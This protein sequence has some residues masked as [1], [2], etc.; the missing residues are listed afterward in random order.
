MMN[1]QTNFGLL[2]HIHRPLFMLRIGAFLF[3]LGSVMGMSAQADPQADAL[4]SKVSEVMR[5]YESIHAT[6]VSQMLDRQSDFD[7]E[8]T[9][10]VW[11]QGEQYHLQLGQYT[12]I[13]D[14]QTVWTH[15]P[16]M[17]ECYVDDAEVIAEDGIDPASMFTI[18]ESGF[19]KV[20]K[21]EENVGGLTLVRV[22]LHPEGEEESSFHTIQCF[23]DED[24][25]EVVKLVVKGREGTDVV[26]T[27]GDFEGDALIPEGAFLF[28]ATK[29]PGVTV[30]DNRL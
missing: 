26:Y 29:F 5:G 6:Y 16:E 7:M 21:G 19:K 23:I 20:M 4:L 13:S 17:G 24:K 12:I 3:I 25:L 15:E 9:G 30:I 8:Q 11:I 18:W 27:I 2:M 28:D 22:D 14:G 1:P 10:E